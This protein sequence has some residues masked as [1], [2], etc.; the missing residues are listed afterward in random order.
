MANLVPFGRFGGFDLG[1]AFGFEEAFR[2]MLGPAFG[3]TFSVDVQDEGDKYKI[4]ADLPGLHR[5]MINVE[6]QNEVLTISANMD[7]ETQSQKDDYV[8]HERRQGMVSRSFSI[9]DVDE[10]AITATYRDGVLTVILPKGKD[11][12]VKKHRVQID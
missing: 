5:E 11:D 10:D 6:V 1:R 2:D 9:S 3:S 4:T 7:S 12:D 8:V